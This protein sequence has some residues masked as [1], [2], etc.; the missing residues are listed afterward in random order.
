MCD[1]DQVW[2]VSWSPNTGYRVDDV[3]RG[4]G[5]EVSVWFESDSFDDVE[6]VVRCEAGQAVA[7]DLV[8]PDDHG[9]DRD[10]DGGDHGGDGE[11][12]SGSNSG[13]G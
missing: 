6:V 1:G 5:A 7:T 13:S 11:D 9:G 4:P 12:R 3:V 8:E 10:E 2:L